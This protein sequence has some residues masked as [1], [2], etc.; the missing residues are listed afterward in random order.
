[1]ITFNCSVCGCSAVGSKNKKYCSNACKQSAYRMV[2][3][4]FS[5]KMVKVKPNSQ[6]LVDCAIAVNEMSK[7]INV[8]EVDCWNVFMDSL[9][10]SGFKFPEGKS[11]T[12]IQSESLSGLLAVDVGTKEKSSNIYVAL[13]DCGAV[14]VGVSKSPKERLEKIS[15]QSG[16]KLVD[17]DVVKVES[18]SAFKI[19]SKVKRSLKKYLLNGEFFSCS[20]QL[21]KEKVY[22]YAETI[23]FARLH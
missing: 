14:K 4:P 1:M 8:S 5:G 10:S 9:I 19:E 22:Q 13:F 2:K 20:Y 18:G 15:F 6:I 23:S 11:L 17:F 3:H 7:I 21:A 16:R 12:D